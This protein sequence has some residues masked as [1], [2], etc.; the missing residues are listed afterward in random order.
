M[1]VPKAKSRTAGRGGH[2]RGLAAMSRL[3]PA[4]GPRQGE[5][6]VGEWF[7]RVPLGT[8]PA[9]AA[10]RFGAREALVF[11]GRRW[12]FEE[13]DR[14][15]DRAARGLLV[16]GVEPGEK[17][18]LW[19]PNRPAWLHAFFGALRIGAVVLP[20]NIRLRAHDL[21][22]ALGA[23]D[24]STLVLADRAG[25]ADFLETVLEIE[26]GL[27]DG[28]LEDASAERRCP[29]LRRVIVDGRPDTTDA[30]G[31]PG[32]LSWEALL[33][34]GEEVPAG[35]LEA[36]AAAVDPDARAL[37]TFTSGS[38]GNPK[39]V[40]HG[41]RLVRNVT[42][43]ANRLGIGPRDR[44]LMYLPLF[45]VFGMYDGALMM[46]LA[47][48]A[49]VLMERFDPD[50]ALRLVEAERCTLIHGFDTHFTDLLSSSELER[51][52]TTSLRGGVLLT[53]MQS[54]VPVARAVQRRLCSTVSAWG[55]TEVGGCACLGSPVDDEE[56]RCTDSG[57]PLPGYEF[58]IVDP[59]ME[60]VLGAGETGEL[61]CRSYML[62][63]EYYR[64]PQ[65]TA[66][67]FSADGWFRT[68]DRVLLHADGSIRFLGRYKDV[69]KVGGENV[70]PFEVEAFLKRHPAVAGVQVVAAPDP[71]LGEVPVAFV[72]P[73]DGHAPEPAGLL[74]FCR[75]R[76]AG[77]KIPR[78]CFLVSEFPMTASGKV[79]RFR[80][81][82]QAAERMEQEEPEE[83]SPPG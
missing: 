46:P 65:A 41:H 11:E 7:E 69:L 53:G 24:A 37:I 64:D 61:Q 40:V 59:D 48:T 42:D 20:L 32:V 16:A 78:R 57:A 49:V 36:I 66:A 30:T 79:Q 83:E 45:H 35:R 56:R 25:P 39:G 38:T 73:R 28:S 13:F 50:A 15:V 52:D 4:F 75:G 17:L 9:R 18:A 68:G 26:P 72:I 70:D 3:E 19:L 74:D 14:D 23:S 21:E 29:L 54:S 12:T 8:L 6:P 71:R 31:L 55:M 2:D 44:T 5:T 82:A 67:A 10:R 22:Y 1:G 62:P 33:R 81:R 43:Q 34:L 63:L 47:G 76:I 58:R 77:F 51:C 27:R 80:L 60:A